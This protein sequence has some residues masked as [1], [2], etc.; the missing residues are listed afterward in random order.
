M[1]HGFT[2][3]PSEMRP[4]AE[5]IHQRTGWRCKSI[6]LPGHGTHVD[7]MQNVQAGDW[8]RAVEEA[9]RELARD[10]KHVFLVGLSMGAVLCCHQAL[11]QRGGT[12][13]KGM[14]LMAP[15]FG[16][17]TRRALTLRVLRQFRKVRSKGPRAAH[18]F[19]D[20][21][22]FHY[23]ETPLNRA[24]EVVKLG[25]EAW[26]NLHQLR[27][28]P[29]LLLSG[30]LDRTVSLD[31]MRSAARRNPWIRWVQLPRSRH[32]LTVEPDSVTAFEA[33]VQFMKE[34]LSWPK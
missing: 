30:D 13:L 6:L 14:V 19:I 26:Q 9:F 7:D 10:C 3:S 31:W 22:I 11:R 20:R 32:V 15:A 18:Y 16:I 4:M 34:C 29:V 1:V 24:A 5:F 2:A 28:V 17:S 23:I 12:A 8:L 27:D 21:K 33:S 25:R